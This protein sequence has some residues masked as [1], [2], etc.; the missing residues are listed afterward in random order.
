[1]T[2]LDREHFIALALVG[3]FVLLAL[4]EAA[5]VR[6]QR[7]NADRREARLFTNFGF[8]AFV[9]LAGGLY[10]LIRVS[11]AA[12]AQRLGIGLANQVALPWLAV[13]AMTLLAQTFVYYWMHRWMHDAPFFW[14]IHRVHHADSAVDVSTSLRK[15]PL[16]LI[17]TLPV[18]L[19]I[20]AIGAPVSVVVACQVVILAATIWQ[21]SDVRLPTK[22]DRALALLIM[23]PRLHRLHHNPVR[24][25]RD[26]NFG[27]LLTIWDRLFGTLS[28]IEGRGRVGLDHQAAHPDYLLEQI[29]SPL[30]RA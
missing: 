3:W 22:V 2:A 28:V 25:V 24:I 20:L 21:H 4:A 8:S 7:A 13:F 5:D 9:L 19:V 26:S 27:E 23:T 14:R 6:K 29:C 30:S 12:A 17:V 16:E 15:H 1:L 18:A 11:A 10:P